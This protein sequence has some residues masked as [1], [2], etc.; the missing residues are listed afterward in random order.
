MTSF[1][2]AILER[3]PPFWAKEVSM[4]LYLPYRK[5]NETRKW[6]ILARSQPK[7]AQKNDKY[8]A[9]YMWSLSIWRK[10][11]DMVPPFMPSRR[12][13]KNP[14]IYEFRFFAFA[15]S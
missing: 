8:G 14:D 5:R 9:A 2:A 4:R 10:H 7:K 15:K 1:G 11:P 13:S 6:Y 12:D 3:V